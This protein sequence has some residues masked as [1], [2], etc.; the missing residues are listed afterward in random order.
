MSKRGRALKDPAFE[1]SAWYGTTV[2]GHHKW[3]WPDGP[4]AFSTPGVH[5]IRAVGLTRI[6]RLALIG[7]VRA[8]LVSV[9]EPLRRFQTHGS[10]F[11]DANERPETVYNGPSAC[12]G[13]VGRV[14]S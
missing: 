4:E 8:E 6:S 5:C 2:N 13:A 14:M 1:I 3:G 12:G 11:Q 9:H 10:R 7:I